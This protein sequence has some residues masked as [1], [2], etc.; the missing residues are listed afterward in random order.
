MKRKYYRRNSDGVIYFTGKDQKNKDNLIN[1]NSGSEM[2]IPDHFYDEQEF[3]GKT[4]TEI[5][6]EQALSEVKT[7]YGNHE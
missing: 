4:M 7:P 3:I 1:L 5:T 6:R 2:F